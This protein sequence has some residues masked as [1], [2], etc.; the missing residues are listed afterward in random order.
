M[1]KW[2]MTAA[3]AL[4]LLPAAALAQ[5][6]GRMD[7]QMAPGMRMGGM[8]MRMAMSMRNPAEFVLNHQRELN[9]TPDQPKKIGKIRDEFQHENGEALSKLDKER[10]ETVKK[11]GPGPY[12][13][14]QREDMRKDMG[15]HR[16]Q[17]AKLMEN[18]RKAM[19]EIR[20]TLS[21]SQQSAMQQI[22]RNDMDRMRDSADRDR[23]HDSDHDRD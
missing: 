16:E 5:D 6:N 13:D 15:E 23:D 12:T 22:M 10:A 20:E 4:V 11:Y 1:R 3:L 9:L 21:P 14:E 2:L 7:G 19:D 17:W 18:R 8:R